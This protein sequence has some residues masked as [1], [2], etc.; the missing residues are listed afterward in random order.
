LGNISKIKNIKIC[1]NTSGSRLIF[2]V[3][4]IRLEYFIN[5]IIFKKSKSIKQQY[6]FCLCLFRQKSAL[7]N[8]LLHVRSGKRSLLAT[9][10]IEQ[11][12]HAPISERP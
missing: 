12:S 9:P 6:S 2:N 5:I 11:K 7:F 8:I 3:F 10:L 4:P 1:V